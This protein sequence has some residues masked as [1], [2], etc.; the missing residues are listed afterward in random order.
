MTAKSVMENKPNLKYIELKLTPR[1]AFL[2]TILTGNMN[3]QEHQ[4]IINRGGYDIEPPF[5]CP[6]SITGKASLEEVKDSF[7][8]LYKIL[9]NELEDALSKG[10]V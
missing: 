1:E 4:N 2:L 5:H 8:N 9:K 10:V 7:P 6:S 3:Q